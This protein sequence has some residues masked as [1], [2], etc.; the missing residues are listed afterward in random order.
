MTYIAVVPRFRPCVDIMMNP[1]VIRRSSQWR[2]LSTLMCVLALQA[3][4]F[5]STKQQHNRVSRFITKPRNEA[6]LDYS[7]TLFQPQPIP[8]LQP[9]QVV[10]SSIRKLGAAAM[11]A[12]FMA[13][14]WS[15]VSSTTPP[16]ILTTTTTRESVTAA[17]HI[18]NNDDL[19]IQNRM[20]HYGVYCG[21]GPADAFSGV[22]A[23]DSVDRVCQVSAGLVVDG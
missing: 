3:E 22:L 9:Y 19:V 12:T 13:S 17:A 7:L 4:G 11:L 23:V 20:L 5:R 10:T 8:A 18:D 21:P 16:T 14:T 1:L 6:P 2:L 15:S